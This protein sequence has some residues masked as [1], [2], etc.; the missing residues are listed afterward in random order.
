M[1]LKELPEDFP[2][3]QKELRKLKLES[4]ILNNLVKRQRAATQELMQKHT[5]TVIRFQHLHSKTNERLS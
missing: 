3:A 1:D 4:K 5:A 2:A